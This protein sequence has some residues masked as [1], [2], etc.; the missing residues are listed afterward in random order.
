[1][2]APPSTPPPSR[3]G[4]SRPR[5]GST[6]AGRPCSSARARTP[7]GGRRW[8]P[9]LPPTSGPACRARCA[10]AG[11]VASWSRCPAAATTSPGCSAAP[12]PRTRAR[13]RSPGPRVA[14][15]DAAVRSWSTRVAGAGA[16][17]EVG[18]LLAHE[19]VHV[20]TRSAGSPAPL[21]VVEGLAELV[22]LEAHPDQRGA[23]V[24]AL[25]SAGDDDGDGLP[26]DAGLRAGR[27]GRHRGVRPGVAGLPR[28]RRALGERRPR[29]PVRGAR[30]GRTPRRCRQGDARRRRV[31]R[32][33]LGTR[34]AVRGP[35]RAGSG[36][37]DP[38]RRPSS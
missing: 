23:E 25:R 3:S 35:V 5:P 24:A 1:M 7:T 15:T 27:P 19:T 14:T 4:G 22:A 38:C 11:T 17:T 28:R 10:T 8:P 32:G 18:T 21:W 12:R 34:G 26:T 30:P 16:D 31:D 20:A 36:G 9:R 33:A 2:T 13:P 37:A 6:G 29:P